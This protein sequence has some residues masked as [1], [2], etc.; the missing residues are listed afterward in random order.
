MKNKKILTIIA[1]IL[2]ILGII[3]IL[4]PLISKTRLEIK[5]SNLVTTDNS[6]TIDYTNISGKTLK[7]KKIVLFFENTKKEV[8]M[9]TIVEIDNLG[10]NET[11][12]YEY[13]QDSNFKEIPKSYYYKDYNSNIKMVDNVNLDAKMT[14]LLQESAKEVIEKN[15]ISETFTDTTLTVNDI[16]KYLNKK[17]TIFHEKEY[18]CSLDE[19]YVVVSKNYDTYN[20]V[21]YINCKIFSSDN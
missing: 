19:S 4:I 11:K 12:T 15:Y 16:E 5:L 8:I 13:N 14:R 10:V 2:F 18:G 1:I 20:Y 7:N 17:L 6:L 3:L 21:T 9:T